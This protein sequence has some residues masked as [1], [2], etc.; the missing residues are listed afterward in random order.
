[1]AAVFCR[2][3]YDSL[4]AALEFPGVGTIEP[5]RLNLDLAHLQRIKLVLVAGLPCGSRLQLNS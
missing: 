2:L 1:M 4:G 3:G 5:M